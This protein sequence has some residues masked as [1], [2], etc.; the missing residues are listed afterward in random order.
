MRLVRAVG[1]SFFNPLVFN[2]KNLVVSTFYS[3]RMK[4]AYFM[5]LQKGKMYRGNML[6]EYLDSSIP[7]VQ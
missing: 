6:I 1:G 3:L 4:E 5:L 7:I 2:A